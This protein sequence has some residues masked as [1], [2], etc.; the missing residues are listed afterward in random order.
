L[1]TAFDVIFLLALQDPLR[2]KPVKMFEL[3]IAGLVAF[4]SQHH[5]SMAES[6]TRW[7]LF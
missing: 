3:L 2:S 1:I 4:F 6:F 7:W 5:P